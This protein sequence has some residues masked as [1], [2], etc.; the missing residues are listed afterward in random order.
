MAMDQEML[1]RLQTTP[2]SKKFV[3][4][5]WSWCDDFAAMLLDDVV[6]TELELRMLTERTKCL[7]H[8]PLRIQNGKD[9]ADTI[10]AISRQL[11]Q[12]ADSDTEG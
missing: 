3:N 11:L 10:R 8:R 6:E 7:W 12:A 9:V 2:E 5:L 4:V 1:I